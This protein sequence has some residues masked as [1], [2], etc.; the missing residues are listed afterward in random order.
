MI[1]LWRVIAAGGLALSLTACDRSEAPDPETP[2]DPARVAYP[3]PGIRLPDVPQEVI[4]V[5]TAARP[6]LVVFEHVPRV[7]ASADVVLG[8]RPSQDRSAQTVAAA[9]FDGFAASRLSALGIRYEEI[10]WLRA[11][12][13]NDDSA[14]GRAL[15]IS[16]PYSEARVVSAPAEGDPPEAFLNGTLFLF[17]ESEATLNRLVA[18]YRDGTDEDDFHYHFLDTPGQIARLRLN[19]VGRLARLAF[20]VLAAEEA[21]LDLLL[22]R[23]AALAE[24]AGPLDLALMPDRDGVGLVIGLSTRSELDA[25]LLTQSLAAVAEAV[26]SRCTALGTP[27]A[28]ALAQTLA[29]LVVAQQ[30][31]SMALDV[32]LSVEQASSLASGL[33]LLYNLP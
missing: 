2:E 4:A 1:R 14:P 25:A 16:V 12:V 29:G 18:L 3:A 17:A 22:P 26:M 21:G 33:F 10:R 30:G 32:S 15:A 8:C 9:L 5:E 7:P 19:D 24:G 20:P 11:Y 13:F 28:T 6:K 23:G 31:S 27:E